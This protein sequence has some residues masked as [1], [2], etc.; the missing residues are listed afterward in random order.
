MLATKN[1]AVKFLR[2]IDGLL[3]ALEKLAL[4]LCFWKHQHK[5]DLYKVAEGITASELCS[6]Q[7]ANWW[8]GW[9][10]LMSGAIDVVV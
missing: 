8:R 5:N 9:F 6:A 7:C 2:W 3:Q 4:L 10:I 1:Q